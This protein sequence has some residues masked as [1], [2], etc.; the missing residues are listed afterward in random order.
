MD[1]GSGVHVPVNHPHWVTTENEVTIS[2]AMT[3]ETSATKKR[4]T[5]FAVN[6]YLR[7]LGL[8]PKSFG[9]SPLRDF[10]QGWIVPGGSRL[11][12]DALWQKET[13][14]RLLM[15]PL[16]AYSPRCT[17]VTNLAEAEKWR[18]QWTALAERSCRLE[19]SQTPL[20]LLTWWQV[21][22]PL[23]GRKLRL[24]LFHKTE[25]LIGLAPVAAAALLVSR[26]LAIPPAGILRLWRA[27][28]QRHLH[29]PSGGAGRIGAG[30]TGRQ[31][32]GACDPAKRVRPMG[33]SRPGDDVRRH[34]NAWAARG[35]LRHSRLHR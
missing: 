4:G 18:A 22:G 30:R 1:P 31:G 5:V 15:T 13:R 11:E 10:P 17:L 28:R 25:R 33:R 14:S 2:L 19:L 35:K 7:R 8:K 26:R 6:R 20:W 3:V 16:P 32:A 9:Q 12:I 29:Q 21:F 23:A 34:S 27:A 24:G